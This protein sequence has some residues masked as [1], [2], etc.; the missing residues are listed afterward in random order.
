MELLLESG[1]IATSKLKAFDA[2][3]LP[4][5]DSLGSRDGKDPA[6]VSDMLEGRFV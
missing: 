6:S 2:Q 3:H 5:P 4:S 1:K